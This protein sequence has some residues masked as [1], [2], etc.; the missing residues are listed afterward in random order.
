[1]S[2]VGL[3]ICKV[4]RRQCGIT[5]VMIGLVFSKAIEVKRKNLQIPRPL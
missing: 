1:M 5:A 2:I 3:S 4:E